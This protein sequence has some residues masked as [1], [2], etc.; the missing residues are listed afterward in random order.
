[1]VSFLEQLDAQKHGRRDRDAA[2]FGGKS[3]THARDSKNKNKLSETA[4]CNYFIVGKFYVKGCEFK[5]GQ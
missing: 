4:H 3:G 2:T 5:T 1:M